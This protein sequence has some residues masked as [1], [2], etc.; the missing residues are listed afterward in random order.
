MAKINKFFVICKKCAIASDN[1]NLGKINI[2]VHPNRQVLM[3]TCYKCG[4]FEDIIINQKDDFFPRDEEEYD[5]KMKGE[6]K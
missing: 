6:L 5:K 4:E 1:K 2:A 3:F